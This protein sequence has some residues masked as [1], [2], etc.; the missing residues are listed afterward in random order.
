MVLYVY[1]C[2]YTHTLG[3]FC[4]CLS[5][6]LPL[7]SSS[8]SYRRQPAPLPSAPFSGSHVISINCTSH[9][10]SISSESSG[11]RRSPLSPPCER[12]PSSS[13][14]AIDI[15]RLHLVDAPSPPPP[16]SLASDAA[17]S[18]MLPRCRILHHCRPLPHCLHRLLWWSRSRHH[19]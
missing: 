11:V 15:H 13:T 1:V 7:S 4:P 17:P 16:S 5:F 12:P 3:P 2:I 14:V 6:F 19:A 10:H 18:L 8:S 9:T